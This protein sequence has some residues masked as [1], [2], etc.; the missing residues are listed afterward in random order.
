LESNYLEDL[1]S[2]GKLI[3][4]LQFISGKQVVRMSKRIGL[5]QDLEKGRS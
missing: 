3:G 5:S 4:L 1:E 2:D